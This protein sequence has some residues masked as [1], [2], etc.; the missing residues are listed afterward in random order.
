MDIA[1]SKRKTLFKVGR[2]IGRAEAGRATRMINIGIVKS[3]RKTSLKVGMQIGFAEAG[4]VRRTGR[5]ND[6]RKLVSLGRLGRPA[7]RII[8]EYTMER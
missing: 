3:Q 4:W 6:G 8:E 5:P 1:R 7:P 2:Q